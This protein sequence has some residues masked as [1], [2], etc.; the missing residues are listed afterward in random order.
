MVKRRCFWPYGEIP[1]CP[2]CDS[3]TKPDDMWV[4]PHGTRKKIDRIHFHK[5]CY[6]KRVRSGKSVFD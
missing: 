3:P 4:Q 5:E 6:L 1:V 2:F